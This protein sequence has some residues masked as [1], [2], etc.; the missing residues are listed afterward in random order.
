MSRAIRSSSCCRSVPP[1]ATSAA[2]ERLDAGGASVLAQGDLLD[3]RLG[4]REPRLALGAQLVALAIEGDR[5]I[6]RRLAAFQP[7]DDRLQ[8]FQRVFERKS[9]DILLLHVFSHA[10]AMEDR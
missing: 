4:G 9:G 7:G 6:Q 3:A 8:P 10:S 5:F 1:R 2:V